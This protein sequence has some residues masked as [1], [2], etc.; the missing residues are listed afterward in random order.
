MNTASTIGFHADQL[1]ATAIDDLV[2]SATDTSDES[3][4]LSEEAAESENFINFVPTMH[5][6]RGVTHG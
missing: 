6:L 3:T 4:E 2:Y 5:F 1:R